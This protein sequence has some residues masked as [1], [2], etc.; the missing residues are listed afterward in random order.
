MSTP[1]NVLNPNRI[2]PECGVEFV[3]THGRQVFC[4]RMH[5]SAFEALQ[6]S[7]GLVMGPLLIAWR[8][9]KRGASENSSYAL[10]ELTSMI[11]AWMREDREAGRRSDIV[12]TEKRLKGWR[13]CDLG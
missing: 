5:K 1:R 10:R 7:R 4:Q 9:G 3:A 6:H 2:C 8:M 12:V 11:D 13:A